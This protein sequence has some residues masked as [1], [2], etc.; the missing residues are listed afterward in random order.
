VADVKHS[1]A[2]TPVGR[3]SSGVS[4]HLETSLLTIKDKRAC[5]HDAHKYRVLLKSLMGSITQTYS[6]TQGEH[7][8]IN[9]T[10]AI[11]ASLSITPVYQ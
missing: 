9:K 1:I 4:D 10:L 8:N 6:L 3:K 7:K 5:V 11:D 2:T